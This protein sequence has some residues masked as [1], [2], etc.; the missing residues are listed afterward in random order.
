MATQKQNP[1]AVAPEEPSAGGS[2]TRNPDGSLTR[3]HHTQPPQGRAKRAADA[4]AAPATD[5]AKE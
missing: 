4:P 5:T 2:Y 1:P 3:T